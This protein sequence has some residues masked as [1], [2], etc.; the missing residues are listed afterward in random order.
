MLRAELFYVT[1]TQFDN[2][3][4]NLPYLRRQKITPATKVMF[5]QYKGK[6]MAEIAKIDIDYVT[7][8]GD[9]VNSNWTWHMLLL[10]KKTLLEV[11][12]IGLKLNDRLPIGKYKGQTIKQIGQK[13]KGYLTWLHKNTDY[14]LSNS[15]KKFF[16][17]SLD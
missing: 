10:W 3:H 6:M 11:K 8:L 16:R 13:N 17:L 5:G 15:T 14:K 1:M 4:L 7:Y 9:K 12:D 2:S